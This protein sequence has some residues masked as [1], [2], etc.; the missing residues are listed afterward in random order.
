M[1]GLGAGGCPCLYAPGV[2]ECAFSETPTS[3][4]A[5]FRRT[6]YSETRGAEVRE[7]SPDGTIVEVDRKGGDVRSC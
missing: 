3:T 6:A 1:L 5:G 7:A 2:R 4:K